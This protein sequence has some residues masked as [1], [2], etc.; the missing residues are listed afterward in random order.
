MTFAIYY[1]GKA[2]SLA[3]LIYIKPGAEVGRDKAFCCSC[4]VKGCVY[5]LIWG[6]VTMCDLAFD[7][8]LAG[9]SL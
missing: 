3:A 5:C 7:A 4:Q 8:A 1:R 9:D 6:A 2:N